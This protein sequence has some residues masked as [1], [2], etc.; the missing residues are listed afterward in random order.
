MEPDLDLIIRQYELMVNSTFQ[1]TSWRQAANNFFL[2]INTTLVAIAA[3]LYNFSQITGIIIGIIGFGITVLW[4]ETIHYF[5]SLNKA[6]FIVIHEIEKKLPIMMFAMEYDHFNKEK[7]Q[8]ATQIECKIP[9]LFAI[10]Y[11]SII[12]ILVMKILG[13]L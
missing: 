6:K 2:A 1:V 10:V 7:R 4:Y 9:C 3:Y 8:I 11:L 13:I 12:V 5:R